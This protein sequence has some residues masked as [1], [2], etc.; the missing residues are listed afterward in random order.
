[1]KIT[2][3]KVKPGEE[4]I[5]VRY[6]EMTPEISDFIRLASRSG[7]RMEGMKDETKQVY[8]FAP[9]DVYYF[10]SVDGMLYACLEKEVYRLRD[11]LEDIIYQYEE[12][13]F[14][15]CT[16]TMALN[17]YRVEWLKSQPEGRILAALQIGEKV[18]ISRKYAETLRRR[19]KEGNRKSGG[20]DEKRTET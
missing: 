12:Y 16:R 4:E 14:V 10:E 8:Y 18:I 15:R 7:N 5:I 11:K 17:L 19:L 3:R 6:H 9:E 1:M 13:G 2:L 20:N